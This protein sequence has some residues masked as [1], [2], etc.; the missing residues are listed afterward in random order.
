MGPGRVVSQISG[1]TALSF[2]LK[3]FVAEHPAGSIPLIRLS[4]T[5]ATPEQGSEGY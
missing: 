3:M 1:L 5:T 2:I 4:G